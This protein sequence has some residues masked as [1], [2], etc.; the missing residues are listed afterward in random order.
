MLDTADIVR[1][2]MFHQLT[3][4]RGSWSLRSLP[5]FDKPSTTAR[6]AAA[7]LTGLAKSRSGY[8]TPV[9]DIIMD[10]WSQ[11]G[12]YPETGFGEIAPTVPFAPDPF[13]KDVLEA[14][15]WPGI[16]SG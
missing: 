11:Y 15:F 10:V 6:S 7:L 4:L 5:V 3:T 9:E 16:V 1:D 13:S 2:A 14:D 8:P 12:S